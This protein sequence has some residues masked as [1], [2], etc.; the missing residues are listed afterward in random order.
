M[1]Q[2]WD[3]PKGQVAFGLRLRRSSLP[4]HRGYASFFAPCLA[5]KSPLANSQ[6]YSFATPKVSPRETRLFL[7]HLQ[8]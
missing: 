4:Y 2:K 5:P 3:F 8:L 7:N 1:T 6:L